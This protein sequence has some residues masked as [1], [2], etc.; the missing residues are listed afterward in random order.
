MP[1]TRGGDGLSEYEQQRNER[2]RANERTL[3]ELGILDAVKA[4]KKVAP[5]DEGA[6]PGRKRSRRHRRAGSDAAWD[7]DG[8]EEGA[9]DSDSE[10][11]GVYSGD[12]LIAAARRKAAKKRA[13]ARRVVRRANTTAPRPSRA[14]AKAAVAATR[15]ALAGES[16]ADEGKGEAG[17]DDTNASDSDQGSDFSAAESSSDIG[18]E[19]SASESDD[20]PPK[21]WQ[22]ARKKPMATDDGEAD[23][24]EVEKIVDMRFQGD[25]TEYRVRW[26]GWPSSADTWEPEEHLRNVM[27]LITRYH[28]GPR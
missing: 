9:S 27:E 18:T 5:K 3:L 10:D 11:E 7:S 16:S 1:S 22:R 4:A 26:K 19:S 24:Y 13:K 15:T 23:Q 28:H 21:R 20:Q 6:A 25:D 17:G 8:S 14:A 12:E 2:I